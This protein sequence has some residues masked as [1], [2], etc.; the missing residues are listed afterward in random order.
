[1]SLAAYGLRLN[2]YFLSNIQKELKMENIKFTKL[3]NI[4]EKIIEHQKE[5]SANE[6]IRDKITILE[7]PEGIDLRGNQFGTTGMLSDNDLKIFLKYMGTHPIY[8]KTS[9]LDISYN[10]LAAPSIGEFLSYVHGLEEINLSHNHINGFDNYP[11]LHRFNDDCSIQKIDLS[12]NLLS[13]SD[14]DALQKSKNFQDNYFNTHFSKNVKHLNLAYNKIRVGVHSS[15]PLQQLLSNYPNLNELNIDGNSLLFDDKNPAQI[16]IFIATAKSHSEIK[17][18]GLENCG[19]DN[20]YIND[21]KQITDKNQ[22]KN[23]QFMEYKSK[24]IEDQ[25]ELEQCIK[26][27]RLLDKSIEIKQKFNKNIDLNYLSDTTRQT[28]LHQQIKALCDSANP[29]I[30]EADN[31]NNLQNLYQKYTGQLANGEYRN[32][33]ILL[34]VIISALL[35]SISLLKKKLSKKDTAGNLSTYTR[36]NLEVIASNND[37][38]QKIDKKEDTDI[39]SKSTYARI[40]NIKRVANPTKTIQEETHTLPS[41]STLSAYGTSNTN[42]AL[43]TNHPS[44][45]KQEKKTD[46]M[47]FIK[48]KGI[49]KQFNKPILDI[50]EYPMKIIIHYDSTTDRAIVNSFKDAIEGYFGKDGC[51]IDPP[52]SSR[53]ICT[54]TNSNLQVHWERFKDEFQPPEVKNIALQSRNNYKP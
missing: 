45:I 44:P 26:E 29:P 41:P 15:N 21:I 10:S 52:E 49:L 38:T 35:Y 23:Q 31:S 18:I 6:A 3:K 17:H 51:E 22:Q 47:N 4:A 20:K 7:F 28:Y 46:K 8:L 54:V 42:Q 11:F 16:N 9:V 53:F 39:K 37:N 34:V 32:Y 33:I 48:M 12:Y 19:M 5:K 24:L 14:I 25:K 43:G 1:M 36:P 13:E 40:N 27:K 2:I 50:T 30:K